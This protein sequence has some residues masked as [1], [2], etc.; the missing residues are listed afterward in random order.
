MNEAVIRRLAGAEPYQRGV[1]YF[2]AGHVRSLN[3]QDS[4]FM[5]AVVRGSRDYT[6]KLTSDDGV[7]DYSCDCPVGSGGE[8]CKH[9]V[10]AGLAWLDRSAQSSKP[11][12]LADAGKLLLKEDKDTL[13]RMLLD[14][15]QD[16]DLLRERLIFYAARYAARRS[17]P[18]SGAA[19]VQKAFEKALRVDEFVPYREAGSWAGGVNR[20]LDSIEQ[21][22]DDGQGDVVIELCESGLKSLTEAIGSVDD[23]DGYAGG[24]LERMQELHFR[25]CQKAKPD[26]ET[27][28]RW[29]FQSEL[30]G[31]FDVFHGAA[32]RYAKI[33]GVRGLKVYRAMAEAKWANVPKQTAKHERLGLSDHFR[34]THIMKSL[35]EVSGDIEELAGVMSRDLSSGYSYLQIAEAYR[36]AGKR[37]GALLW[38]EKGLQAFPL[39]PDGRLR[40]FAAEEYH[41]LRRHPDAMKL[42]WS[43]FLEGLHLG[44]YQTLERH[45]K[46]A[47]AWP[48]WREKALAEIRLRIVKANEIARGQSRVGWMRE[49]CDH[50]LLVE[51]FRFEGDPEEAWREAQEGGCSGSL[52]LRLAD[53]REK[54][55]PEDAAPVYLKHA[56]AAI[57]V[58][59][60]GRYEDPVDL[61]IKAA[62]AMKRMDRGAEFLRS[63]EALRVKYKIKRN[64]IKLVEQN[65][66][67]LYLA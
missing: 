24:L 52:W 7:L 20:A 36:K 37:D 16:D 46:T 60:N 40:E 28:A 59:K 63:M 41:R 25:A 38:A 22:L 66:K 29:L 47:G 33:L 23:S 3:D 45:A 4:E 13:A 10:A 5:S 9:C 2:V 8:F 53:Q 62:S 34:I 67:S 44:S 48:E 6:V 27:L 57:A 35:A 56:E 18:E 30:Y 1:D 31:E 54:Q 49:T 15:A 50:S 42:M 64:F 12:T 58:I 11:V 43:G 19:T 14:W 39:H 51:I 65:R 55:H 61:L 32:A 17:G 26:P 21:L